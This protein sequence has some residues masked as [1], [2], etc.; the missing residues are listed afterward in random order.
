MVTLEYNSNAGG[1][2]LETP[3]LIGIAPELPAGSTISGGESP[4]AAGTYR[5]SFLVEDLVTGVLNMYQGDNVNVKK[6]P[7][8]LAST[9]LP[10]P[11][12]VGFFT[13]ATLRA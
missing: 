2:A 11:H 10:H 9:L 13:S 7:L 6:N 1:T 12:P 3:S 8:I 4:P 5:T